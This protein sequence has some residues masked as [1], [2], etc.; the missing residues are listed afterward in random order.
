M[1]DGQRQQ[2]TTRNTDAYILCGEMVLILRGFDLGCSFHECIN[3]ADRELHVYTIHPST[4]RVP[5][6]TPLQ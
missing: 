4:S 1:L 2:C 6:H 5:N 3:G